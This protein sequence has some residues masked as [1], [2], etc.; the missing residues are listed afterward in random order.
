MK[1]TILIE[2]LDLE[3]SDHIFNILSSDYISKIKEKQIENMV[4]CPDYED[5][6]EKHL[7][8]HKNILRKI[9]LEENL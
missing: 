5:W 8:W 2:G 7:E 9:K 3:E 1:Y 4:N 6:Y